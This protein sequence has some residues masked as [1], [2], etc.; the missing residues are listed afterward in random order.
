MKT[1]ISGIIYAVVVLLLISPLCADFPVSWEDNGVKIVGEVFIDTDTFLM[2]EFSNDGPTTTYTPATLPIGL[3][4]T[5]SDGTLHDVTSD[6]EFSGIGDDW[7]FVG[8]MH[9]EIDYL[10]G[11]SFGGGHHIE[12][13]GSDAL[14]GTTSGQNERFFN[15]AIGPISSGTFIADEG[16]VAVPEPVA[17]G[18]GTLALL[19]LV[20][21]VPRG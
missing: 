8:P 20:A 10:E 6:F 2:T 1:L 14:T 4:A 21:M 3:I 9:F 5:N 17:I 19:S 16:T 11:A 15:L 18:L 12:W 7:S 13:G